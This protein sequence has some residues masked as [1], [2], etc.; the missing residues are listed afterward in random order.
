MKYTTVA[1]KRF[2]NHFPDQI[3]SINSHYTTGPFPC[4]PYTLKPI[5]TQSETREKHS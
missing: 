4:N 3:L 1:I 5:Q 2:R